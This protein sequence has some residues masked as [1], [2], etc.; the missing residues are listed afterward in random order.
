MDKYSKKW[1]NDKGDFMGFDAVIKDADAMGKEMSGL[2]EGFA[3][4]MENLPDEI[5]KY[6]TGEQQ[7][8]GETAPLSG[9]IK[10]VSEETATKLGGQMNAIRI[11]QLEATELIR[12]QLMHLSN[13]AHNTSYNKYIKS[14]YDKMNSGD[15]SLRSQGFTL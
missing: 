6:F 12:Q 10:G 3:K 2:G 9:A 1:I 8:M 7:A 14:I 13:I 4:A 11:N 15:S 5:K